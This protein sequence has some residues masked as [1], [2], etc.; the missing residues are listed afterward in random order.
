MDLTIALFYRK[1]L[2]VP[3]YDRKA[4]EQVNS[5]L[6]PATRSCITEDCSI[7]TFTRV[8]GDI[9]R[10]GAERTSEFFRWVLMLV[11]YFVA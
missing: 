4:G 8:D 6:F 1:G 9:M 5:L 2:R 3:N 11:G 10:G 7:R